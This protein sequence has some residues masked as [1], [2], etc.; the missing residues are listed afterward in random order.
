[1]ILNNNKEEFIKLLQENPE[2]PVIFMVASEE[3]TDY[4]YSVFENF[5]PYI[6]TVYEYNDVYFDDDD[7][8]LECL[9]DDL[10]DDEKYKDLSDEEYEKA[11][12]QYIEEEIVH[13]KA[14]VV[15]IS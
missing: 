13:Y 9:M 7:D 8:I 3:I 15:Y 11:I 5:T 14:I 12:K 10:S 2:L 1:M 6:R 4:C